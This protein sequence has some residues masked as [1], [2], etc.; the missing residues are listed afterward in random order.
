MR[1]QTQKN[2]Q[3]LH[4]NIEGFAETV[5]NTLITQPP[6]TSDRTGISVL[7]SNY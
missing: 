7:M 2:S 4:A 5:T 3:N 6:S 1:F